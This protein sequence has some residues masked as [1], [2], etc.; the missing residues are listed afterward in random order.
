MLASPMKTIIVG[1]CCGASIIPSVNKQEDLDARGCPDLL[2]TG[3]ARG[4][5]PAPLTDHP[6]GDGRLRLPGALALRRDPAGQHPLRLGLRLRA[7]QARA[8][9]GSPGPR[10]GYPAA[11]R[12]DPCG[13]PGL[14]SERRPEGEGQPGQVLEVYSTS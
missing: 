2:A 8:A 1:N 11:R 10:S 12:P 4:A 3:A 9:R 7:I 14:Q 13:E 6:E 5:H